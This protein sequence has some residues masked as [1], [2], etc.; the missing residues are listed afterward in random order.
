MFVYF[1]LICVVVCYRAGG[2]VLVASGTRLKAD[3]MCWSPKVV[4]MNI[5]HEHTKSIYE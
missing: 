2:S 4:N 5:R 3:R 1:M